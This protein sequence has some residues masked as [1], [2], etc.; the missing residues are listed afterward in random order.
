MAASFFTVALMGMASLGSFE[1]G[2]MAGIIGPSEI[3]LLGSACC[4]V[5]CQA[6]SLYQREGVAHIS[7]DGDHH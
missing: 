5:V 1:A 7:S 2:T 4:F 6:S 3:L